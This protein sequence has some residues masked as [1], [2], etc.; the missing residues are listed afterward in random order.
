[1]PYKHSGLL[2]K[3]PISD[4]LDI[5]LKQLLEGSNPENQLKSRYYFCYFFFQSLLSICIYS[6]TVP[7]IFYFKITMENIFHVFTTRKIIVGLLYTSRQLTLCAGFHIFYLSCFCRSTLSTMHCYQNCREIHWR[8][9][10]QNGM[11]SSYFI[12]SDQL[13]TV[14]NS[15]VC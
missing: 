7:N 12:R 11:R 4:C 9:S 2:Q 3:I 6:T 10:I 5:T 14:L 8:V 13:Q 1:M 15:K